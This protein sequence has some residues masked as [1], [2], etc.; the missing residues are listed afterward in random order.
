MGVAGDDEEGVG[1][2][3]G[4]S[5]DNKAA[6]IVEWH[7]DYPPPPVPDVNFADYILQSFQSHTQEV[8][9]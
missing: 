7:A 5:R 9:M 2:V 8:A 3:V 6:R 4:S 1:G